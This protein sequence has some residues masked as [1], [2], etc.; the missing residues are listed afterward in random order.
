M[1]KI[2]Q[3]TRNGDR[4]TTNTDDTAEIARREN[5]TL[6]DSSN[7]AHTEVTGL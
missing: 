4:L 6:D 3:T 5:E 2:V 1:A 7:I